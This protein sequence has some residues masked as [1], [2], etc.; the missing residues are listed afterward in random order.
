M[1]LVN[2]HWEAWLAEARLKEFCWRCG[3]RAY[4][5]EQV[6]GGGSRKVFCECDKGVEA[7]MEL[8][9]ETKNGNPTQD[10]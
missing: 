10:Q 9:K 5:Y 7:R 2:D 4:W 8:E 6:D 1:S 3:N